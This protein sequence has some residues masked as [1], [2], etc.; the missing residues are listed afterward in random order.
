VQQGFDCGITV[1][2]FTDFA[3]GDV[4]EAYVVEQQNL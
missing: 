2:D 4:I 3:E 1:E